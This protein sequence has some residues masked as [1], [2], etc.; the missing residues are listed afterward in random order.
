MPIE[1]RL[2]SL[3]KSIILP[4]AWMLSAY[5]DLVDVYAGQ[6]PQADEAI[7]LT[8]SSQHRIVAA[9]VEV[10]LSQTALARF[11]NGFRTDVDLA[12]VQ[13]LN[14]EILKGGLDSFVGMGRARIL[15]YQYL[16]YDLYLFLSQ[17]GE[18]VDHVAPTLL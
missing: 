10:E 15:L 5:P 8:P 17:P 6:F 2:I 14:R 3:T 16:E 7:V 4:A 1:R 11:D 12:P 13:D 9:P 18:K